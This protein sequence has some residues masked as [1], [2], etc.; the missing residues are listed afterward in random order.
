MNVLY[1]LINEF[2]KEE[3]MNIVA[4][5]ILSLAIT[6]VQ[7]NAISFVTANIIQSMEN[8]Q[9]KQIW[10]FFGYFMGISALFFFVYYGF[11]MVQNKILTKL[12][13]WL[14]HQIFKIILLSNN[15]SM[16]HVNFVEFITPITRIAVSCYALFFDLVTVII[17]MLAFLSIISMYFCYKN[18]TFG[19][20]FIMANICIVLYLAYFWKD[21]AKSK[22]EHEVKI[23]A[24]EKFIID[25]LNNIDKVIYR[26][27]TKN[28]I[29]QFSQMTDE[30]IQSGLSFLSF[31]T[32]HMMMMTAIV[33]VIL[34]ASIWYL[35]K[36]KF[37]KKID[38]TIFITFFTILLLY[39][40]KILNAIQNMPDYLEFIGRLE[41][42]LDDFNAM[43]GK[44]QNIHDIITKTYIPVQL[45]FKKIQFRNVSF[46]YTN[47]QTI[48]I[49]DHLTIDVD[50]YHKII[51][52]TGLSGKGKSS[53]AKL[54]LRLYEP[55]SGAIYIDGVDITTIDP[56]YIRENITYVNQNS[57]LFDKK[58]IENMVYGCNSL[59]ACQNHLQEIMR[60]PKIRQLY[61]NV[62]VIN[63]KAG[64]LGENLSG[65]Q[66]QVVNII[67]GLINPSKI[68][69]LDEPTNALDSD[70]KGEVLA[71]IQ[72]FRQYKQC[73]IIITHDRDVYSLFD[74]TLQI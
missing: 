39:R 28:E 49:F 29:D 18:M 62:D 58:I 4:L 68:L 5:L 14:K 50:T 53:F 70:L 56:N 69:I 41:Y 10:K 71:M 7:T 67:S 20:L 34:F 27:Q 59:E 51:G 64:S 17:P 6:I 43:L 1:Y 74:E 8:N 72:H 22:N 15:E 36:L 31:T 55:T 32:F 52:M 19:S 24:N 12:T 35:I 45:E 47:K 65:G 33:Y 42:I 40:D 48:P 38:S 25:I 2:F 44:K 63:S 61:Q 23:N 13:Q 3:K 21:L 66:R 11:K 57:R 16:N 60:Y 46:T 54:I 37:N 73:I 26:G 9:V 30:G